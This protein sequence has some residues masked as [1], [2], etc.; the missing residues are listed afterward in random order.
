MTNAETV[1]V[2]YTLSMP[3]P[4]LHYFVVGLELFCLKENNIDLILPVWRPGRYYIF[5]FASGVQEFSADDEN[6]NSLLWHKTN[7]YTWHIESLNKKRLNKI[8]IFYKVYADGFEMRTRGL[9]EEHAFVNGTAVFMY[10]EKYRKLPVTLKVV[11]YKDWHVT[12][13]LENLKGK[14]FEFS[15]P[16]YDYFV[17]SPLEIGNQK[18][19]SF[20]VDGK[21][22]VISFFGK[23]DYDFEKLKKDFSVII[24]KNY[25]FWGK[26]PYKKYVFII[27]CTPK[28]SGGTEHI[29]STII[30]IKPSDFGNEE[31]YKRMLRLVSH[32]FFHTWNV[33]Q[34]RPKGITPYDYTKE[35]Y[36][37]ELWIAEGSTSYYDGLMIL[38]TG[39]ISD[40]DFLKEIS[41]E[42]KDERT[43]P[44]YNIQSLAGSCFDAWI[45]FWKRSEN[46]YNSQSD[47]YKKGADLSLI[48]DLEIRQASRNKYSLDDVF[49]AM[50]EKFPPGKGYTNSD[51]IKI[52]EKFSGKSLKSFFDDY[53]YSTK[54]I[55]WETYLLYAGLKL[56]EEESTLQLK[57][58]IVISGFE[59][60]VFISNVLPGSL[61]EK[62][63]L[64]MEDEIIAIDGIK[65]D[66]KTA[67]MK[68][69]ELQPGEE[70]KLAVF[71]ENVLKEINIKQSTGNT[72][73]F[74]IEKIPNSTELQ[75]SIFEKWLG[76]RWQKP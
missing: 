43:R 58:G 65:A 10:S 42:V 11:P 34:F 47:Y 27:H 61:A 59:G 14:K 23:A 57:T 29:N 40:E 26:V 7:K 19:Y 8:N 60:K 20:K 48:L 68:L 50:F 44:G 15:A 13:G 56:T 70:V 4:S 37:E 28:S 51:F 17:D 55:D 16:N 46:A 24:K 1:T 49:K 12:T 72:V 67:E 71:H 39:Q 62:E 32:E 74:H 69:T 41:D 33:K 45:K 52:C 38:R 21:E 31:S 18:D 53:L 36:T 54:P 30:G 6:N 3:E 73:D 2:K 75:K 25:E 76:V 63:G 22:H 66:Y 5:D 35:N 64:S 9:D